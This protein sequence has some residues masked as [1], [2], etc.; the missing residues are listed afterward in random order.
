MNTVIWR[1]NVAVVAIA[2]FSVGAQSALARLARSGK[3]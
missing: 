1:L 2:L 3:S